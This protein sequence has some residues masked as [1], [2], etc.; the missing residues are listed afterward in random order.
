MALSVKPIDGVLHTLGHLNVSRVGP[1]GP[2]PAGGPHLSG[3]APYPP[4]LGQV[5]SAPTDNFRYDAI[6]S[7]DVPDDFA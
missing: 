6:Q 5:L 7:E 2:V 4:Y 1:H 3:R